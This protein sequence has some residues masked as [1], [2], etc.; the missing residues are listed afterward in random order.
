MCILLAILPLARCGQD[1]APAAL[2]FLTAFW[3]GSVR[4]YRPEARYMRGPGSKWRERHGRNTDG[5]EKPLA[6]SGDQRF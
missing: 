3:G 5:I 4:Q 6:S 2:N 1:F